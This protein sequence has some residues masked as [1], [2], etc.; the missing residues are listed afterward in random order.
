VSTAPQDLEA[1]QD[2]VALLEIQARR[3]RLAQAEIQETTD[4][5]E[6]AVPQEIRASVLPAATTVPQ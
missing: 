2:L 3:V 5:E 1:M 6:V 4:L